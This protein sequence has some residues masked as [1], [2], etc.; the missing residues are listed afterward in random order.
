M[1]KITAMQMVSLTTLGNLNNF[2]KIECQ[3]QYHRDSG[4]NNFPI[5]LQCNEGFTLSEIKSFGLD[6]KDQKC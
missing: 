6:K 2:Q 4:N 1:S 5:S 3:E